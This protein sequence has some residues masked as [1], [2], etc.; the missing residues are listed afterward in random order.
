VGATR[1]IDH[2][3][4]GQASRLGARHDGLPELSVTDFLVHDELTSSARSNQVARSNVIGKALDHPDDAGLE[5]VFD[6]LIRG[7]IFQDA[8][9]GQI[10]R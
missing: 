4:R 8:C 10:P 2:L 3:T 6:D 7:A 9:V 5:A 1:I